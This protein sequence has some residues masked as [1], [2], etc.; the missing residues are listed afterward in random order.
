MAPHPPY[1]PED[2]IQDIKYREG[3]SM[4]VPYIERGWSVDAYF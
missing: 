2:A 1:Y 3:A 4:L